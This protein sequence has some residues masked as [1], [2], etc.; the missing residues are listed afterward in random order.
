[1]N[2]E[3]QQLASGHIVT[4]KSTR[5]LPAEML[6]M[7]GRVLE[8]REDGKA[9]VEFTARAGAIGNLVKVALPR[10]LT[11]IGAVTEEDYHD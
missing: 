11:I 5:S 10:D 1:M 8:I 7:Y 3:E 6:G 2:S 9:R 4:V